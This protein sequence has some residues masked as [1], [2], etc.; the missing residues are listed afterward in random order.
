MIDLASCRQTDSRTQHLS[1]GAPRPQLILAVHTSVHDSAAAVHE[2]YTMRAAVQLERLTRIKND[3]REDADLAVDEVLSI[4]GATRKDVDVVVHTRDRFPFEFFR[5]IRW[6]R[7][8]NSAI[9]LKRCT[10]RESK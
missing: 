8:M 4:V 9:W 7:W 3:G 2:D 6:A 5:R 10:A 1:L